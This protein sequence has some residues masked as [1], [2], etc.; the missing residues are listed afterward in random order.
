MLPTWGYKQYRENQQRWWTTRSRCKKDIFTAEHEHNLQVFYLCPP[1]VSALFVPPVA[2]SFWKVFCGDSHFM[3]WK[4][5]AKNVGLNSFSRKSHAQLVGFLHFGI[6]KKSVVSTHHKVRVFGGIVSSDWTLHLKWFSHFFFV[7]KKPFSARFEYFGSGARLGTPRFETSPKKT[8]A[9]PTKIQG[10]DLVQFSQHFGQLSQASCRPNRLSHCNWHHWCL[11]NHRH[12]CV[13]LGVTALTTNAAGHASSHDAQDTCSPAKNTKV[14]EDE[15][16]CIT[17]CDCHLSF[18]VFL[19]EKAWERWMLMSR[20]SLQEEYVYRNF[21]KPVS[22]SYLDD[23]KRC[24]FILP[25]LFPSFRC[26]FQ[27]QSSNPKKPSF[28][29]SPKMR[30]APPYLNRSTHIL[31]NDLHILHP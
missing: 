18:Q 26:V 16:Q 13:H 19:R 4:N 17:C 28:H 15:A 14:Y 30:F 21:L 10:H 31:G 2:T 8:C 20:V 1:H 7:K 9:S 25:Y 12:L 24:V 11:L 22:K 3:E 29:L 27:P 23:W 5:P 6:A